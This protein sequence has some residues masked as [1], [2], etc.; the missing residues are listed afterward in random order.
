MLP[1]FHGPSDHHRSCPRHRCPGEG[2]SSSSF[3]RAINLFLKL[4]RLEASDWARTTK[5]ENGIEWEW[6]WGVGVAIRMH[7][8][9]RFEPVFKKKTFFMLESSPKT[10]TRLQTSITWSPTSILCSS[11]SRSSSI[12][13]SPSSSSTST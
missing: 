10:H 12:S 1:Y 2:G 3:L 13:S 7:V 11:F 8:Y 5:K 9:R 4:G 6:C